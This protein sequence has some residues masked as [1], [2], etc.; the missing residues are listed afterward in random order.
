M[1]ENFETYL[2]RYCE[3][4][5]LTIEEAMQHEIIKEV[6]KYYEENEKERTI[7]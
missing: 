3:M 5:N 7:S 1:N 6:Q 2:E 4:R